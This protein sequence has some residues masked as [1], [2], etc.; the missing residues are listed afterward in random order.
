MRKPEPA[1]PLELA[2]ADTQR[3]TGET[4]AQLEQLY[5]A[6]SA[7]V[8]AF[9]A[10]QLPTGEQVDAVQQLS[11]QLSQSDDL[12]APLQGLTSQIDTDVAHLHHRPLEQAR[13]QFKTISGHVLQ[14][15]ASARGEQAEAELIHFYCSMV[16]SGNANW[17]QL[18]K[19]TANPYMGSKMLRCATHEQRL[20]LPT[21][22]EG[23]EMP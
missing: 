4:G 6:Y 21:A 14:L 18:E 19:P 3:I 22:T 7:L 10:D 17:L 16:P 11:Q 12:P 23:N 20:P 8:T 2:I 5:S 13:E 15:A 9:A 1:G